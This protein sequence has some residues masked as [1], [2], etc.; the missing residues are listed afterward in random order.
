MGVPKVMRARFWTTSRLILWSPVALV[1]LALALA[2]YWSLAMPGRTHAGP[3]PPSTPEEEALAR[4][5]ARHVSVLAERIGERHVREPVAL[6]EAAAYVAAELERTGRRPAAQ[7]FVAHGVSCRNVELELPGV[8]RRDEIVVVGA[9]YDTAA[10]TPGANDNATGV[11]ALL[12]LAERLARRPHPRTLRF[13]GFVNEEPPFFRSREMGSFVYAARSRQ[14]GEALV[15]MLSLETLGYYADAPG[16][17]R[18]PFPLGLLYPSRGDFIA[19]VSDTGSRHVLHV[20]IGAF[21]GGTP[22]PSLGAALPANTE[23]SYSDQWSFWEHG[24]PGVMVTDT[25]LLRYPHY[26][27]PTDT[28]DR[29]DFPRLARVVTGLDAVVSRLASDAS[30]AP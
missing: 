1:G 18:Y 13:V 8:E 5:L 22:F 30:L 28:P 25:A 24:Y 14:R 16:S 10:G 15:A 12:V 11:A 19:F 20:A 3:T 26:H 27:E 21:R 4:E 23:V 6:A 2:T 9:H 7:D 17:Q 29:V